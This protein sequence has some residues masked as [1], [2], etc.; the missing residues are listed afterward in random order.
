MGKK[1]ILS[2]LFLIFLVSTFSFMV[3]AGFPDLRD[4]DQ[5]LPE[6][7]DPN[8]LIGNFTYNSKCIDGGAEIRSDGTICGQRLEVF[9]ITSVN[10][11]KQ[12]VTVLENFI[13]QGNILLSIF[14]TTFFILLSH[15]S[16][17]N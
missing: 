12:N 6:L 7:K 5:T 3:S 4:G 8:T 13:I 1:V 15:L 9:N 16:L 10:V 17:F 14:F 11:T 2:F